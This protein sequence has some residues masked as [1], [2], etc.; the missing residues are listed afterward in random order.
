M[1]IYINEKLVNRN[2]KLGRI[3][4]IAGIII[5]AGGMYATIRYP[6]MVTVAWLALLVG[7]SLSQL[8]LYYGNRWGRKPRPDET[9]DQ[10]LKGLD[11]RYSIYHYRTPIP[12][13]LVGPTGIW[14][15]SPFYQTGKIVY[16]KKRWRHKGGGF[17]QRYLRIFGQEG[18]GRP[19]LEIPADIENVRRY[20]KRR[21]NNEEIEIPP[22]KAV[23]V[24]T[25]E[26][27]EIECGDAPYPTITA[28][29]L[30]EMIRKIPKEEMLSA[31][32]L[33]A[34]LDALPSNGK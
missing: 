33:K 26:N 9:L 1:N 27:V 13:L 5:L 30:K 7:F 22:A 11:G 6:E 24:F 19:D 12:H 8:G 29:A 3:A 18:L 21:L 28:K 10:A 31:D 15:L 16:E 32:T 2:A 4:S 17:T 25:N 34:I 20:F 14:V 23:L